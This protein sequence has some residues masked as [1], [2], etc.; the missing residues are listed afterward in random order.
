MTDRPVTKAFGENAN[1]KR[2]GSSR[3]GMY[4]KYKGPF[5]DRV[6]RCGCLIALFRAGVPAFMRLLF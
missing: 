4:R 5:R 3:V 1:Q 6:K 2:I